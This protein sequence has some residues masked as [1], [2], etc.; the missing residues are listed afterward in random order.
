MFWIVIGAGEP[1]MCLVDPGFQ[2]DVTIASD[3]RTFYLV[4]VG[5][6]PV[7]DAVGSGQPRLVGPNALTRRMP[8]VLQRSRVAA[9]VSSTLADR[10]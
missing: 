2:F 4:W 3:V 1:W 9:I 8:A 10:G 6:L 5:K 7:K